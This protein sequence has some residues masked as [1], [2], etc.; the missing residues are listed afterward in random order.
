MAEDPPLR[1]GDGSE[2][3]ECQESDETDVSDGDSYLAPTPCSKD[4]PNSSRVC[5]K[6]SLPEHITAYCEKQELIRDDTPIACD[7]AI[8][9]KVMSNY[10]IA[11]EILSNLCWQDKMLCRLVCTTWRS[12][13][14]TLAREQVHLIDFVYDTQRKVGHHDKLIKSD[15]FH[16]TPMAV[17]VFVN[18]AGSII[19]AHCKDIIP[20]PC[21]TPCTEKVHSS[22]L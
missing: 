2:S 22:K 12:A 8:V 9:E 10:I 18:N 16:N 4:P 7:N 13:V 5:S 6:L 11:K 20:C 3:S 14:N 1:L 15:N 19:T 21:K 17:F